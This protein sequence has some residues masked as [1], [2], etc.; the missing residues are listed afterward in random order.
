MSFTDKGKT[1]LALPPAIA[2][3]LCK[4]VRGACHEH[5]RLVR[6]EEKDAERAAR[7]PYRYPQR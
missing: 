5:E 4:S 1:H 3:A 2:D 7:E 6:L